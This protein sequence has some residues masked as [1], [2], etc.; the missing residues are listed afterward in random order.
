MLVIFQ[1]TFFALGTLELYPGIEKFCLFSKSSAIKTTSN[2]SDSICK[3]SD[4]YP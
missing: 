2:Y 4:I 3:N 1:L